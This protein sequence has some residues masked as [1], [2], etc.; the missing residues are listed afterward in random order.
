MNCIRET[1]GRSGFVENCSKKENERAHVMMHFEDSGLR[2]LGDGR[3]KWITG[4]RN[5]LTHETRNPFYREGLAGVCPTLEQVK[6]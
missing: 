5:L 3:A 2:S 1:C 4:D 6:P